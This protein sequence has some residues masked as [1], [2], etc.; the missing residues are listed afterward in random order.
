MSDREPAINLNQISRFNKAA[1]DRVAAAGD[2]LYVAATQTQI[3]AARNGD[4]K[5]RVT[6]VKPVPREW[7]DPIAG[8]SILLLA[9]GGGQQGPLLSAAGAD[10]TVFDLSS[11]QL[12]R[13]V[14]IASSAGLDIK[15]ITGDM[16][17][18][19]AVEDHSFDLIINPCST[20]FVPDL[21]PVW[22]ECFRVLNAGGSLISGMINPVW[23]LFDA[24][25][26]DRGKLVPRHRI[27]YSDYDLDESER[28]ALLGDERPREF[29]HSLD[30]LIGS[31]LAAGFAIDGFYQDRWGDDDRL[32]DLIDV[33]IA[34]RAT[35]PR[36]EP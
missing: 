15:T 12:Q 14:A 26:M 1:W 10:V 6:P 18:L 22:S 8:R 24:A 23:Y 27:P 31:Q 20:C 25:K 34:T 35:K 28:A 13:D 21:T 7:I 9:G 30:S 16:A 33:F 17:D 11:R 19:S 32:S 29:G 2:A 5:I 36:I 3:D 4:W